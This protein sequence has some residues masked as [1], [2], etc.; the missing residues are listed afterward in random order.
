MFDLSLFYVTII[1]ISLK[2]Y[3]KRKIPEGNLH[4]YI[5]F[6]IFLF[7]HLMNHIAVCAT[8]VHGYK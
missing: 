7:E 3:W 5:I 2:Q 1:E 4:F 6:V 8:D